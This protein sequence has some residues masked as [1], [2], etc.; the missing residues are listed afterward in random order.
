MQQ[1]SQYCLFSCTS[2]G[3]HLQHRVH[4]VLQFSIAAVTV[5]SPFPCSLQ[6]SLPS[7]YINSPLRSSTG[8]WSTPCGYIL[9]E[10]IQLGCMHTGL[11][12]WRSFSLFYCV[13]AVRVC[14]ACVFH[15]SSRL[16]LLRTGSQAP[17]T[18]LPDP[19]DLL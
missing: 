3:D 16:R 17:A 13:C 10:K 15:F 14:C 19:T 11:E 6:A 9:G 2:T 5:P 18:I 1:Q 7:T 4:V 12:R 8:R